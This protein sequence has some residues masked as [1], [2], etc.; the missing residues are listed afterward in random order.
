M[1]SR[2]LMAGLVV[3]GGWQLSQS[4]YLLAKAEL[5]QWLL[6]AAWQ[7]MRERAKPGSLQTDV[8]PPWPWADTWPVAK[9]SWP[10]LDQELIVLAGA[11]GRNLAFGPAHL[12]ASV[13]PG[14]RGVSVIG[15]HR[16][17]HFAFLQNL[18]IGDHFVLE[19]T[20]GTRVRYQ[21]REIHVTDVRESR[22]ALDSA[23]PKIAL[24]AC[25]PFSDWQAG[26][27]L[28]YLVIAEASSQKLE[29]VPPTTTEMLTT[30]SL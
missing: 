4:A 26:S 23:V 17:T 25:Y 24:V 11:S 7:E 13:L 14:E 21:V 18:V 28:R 16:D 9:L 20:D 6:E 1:K 12:S 27:P 3:F 2:L 10:E 8:V 19:R 30:M 29:P 5:A 22:I 15:G